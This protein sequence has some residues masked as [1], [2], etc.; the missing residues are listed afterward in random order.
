MV[1]NNLSCCW[2][3]CTIECLTSLSLSLHNIISGLP[4][5]CSSHFP[6]PS[7]TQV[8]CKTNDIVHSQCLRRLLLR[9][10]IRKVSS[11]VVEAAV[12]AVDLKVT[13]ANVSMTLYARVWH[14][15]Q[16]RQFFRP[17]QILKFITRGNDI[18]QLKLNAIDWR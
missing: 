12:P 15:I 17:D 8:V 18:V 3:R 10:V 13:R 16:C 5:T 4:T 7:Q 6:L 9:L 11:W 1:S 2:I 14:R